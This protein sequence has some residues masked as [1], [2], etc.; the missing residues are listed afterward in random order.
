MKTK[1]VVFPRPNHLCPNCDHLIASPPPWVRLLEALSPGTGNRN[2]VYTVSAIASKANLTRQ[3][4]D[5][6]I[7]L[8]LKA[9]AI[10][11]ARDVVGAKAYRKT[12]LGTQ[13][14]SRWIAAGWEP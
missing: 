12:K 13:V 1:T 14:L 6:M 3:W 2:V 9:K 10:E 4:A 8:A 11:V 5:L 7:P